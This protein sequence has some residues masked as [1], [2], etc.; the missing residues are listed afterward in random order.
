MSIESSLSGHWTDEQLIEHLYGIGPDGKHIEQCSDCRER[1]S[2]MVAARRA[3]EAEASP[4]EQVP[5]ELLTRQRRS[6][7]ARIAQIPSWRLGVQVRRWAAAAAMIALLGGG[8]FL[9]EQNQRQHA[10]QNKVTDAQLAQEVSQIAG[11]SEPSP[12]APL[13]E[14]FV[15]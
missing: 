10:L 7:Y 6:I 4:L 5:F 2:R 15:E 1:L 9:Y 3:I 13:Q 12:T 8:A 11:D 14:L